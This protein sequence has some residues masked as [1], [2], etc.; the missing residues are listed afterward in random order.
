MSIRDTIARISRW[1]TEREQRRAVS[2]FTCSHCEHN[3]SCG[4]A[5]SGECIDKLEQISRGDQWRYQGAS[6]VGDRRI[7]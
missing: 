3:A 2:E 1:I 5:P 6:H 4:R 7:I